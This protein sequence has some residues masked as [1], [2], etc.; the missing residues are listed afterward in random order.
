MTGV[1]V[2]VT[3]YDVSGQMIK[4]TAGPNFDPFMPDAIGLPA[5]AWRNYLAHVG[6]WEVT[7]DPATAKVIVAVSGNTTTTSV[8]GNSYLDVDA[9][10]AAVRCQVGC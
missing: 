3:E 8:S 5:W 7:L 4:Q 6:A 1:H 9:T 2:G 10:S